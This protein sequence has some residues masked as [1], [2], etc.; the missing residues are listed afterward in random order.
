MLVSE[1]V[2]GMGDGG[3]AFLILEF[4][5]QYHHLHICIR[6]WQTVDNV[7]TIFS[8]IAFSLIF[9]IKIVITTNSTEDQYIYNF[10]EI[11][12]TNRV[13]IIEASWSPLLSRV[14]NFIS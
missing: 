1:D 11:P 8:Q 3:K 4:S 10:H 6:S 9:I 2:S 12:S 14:N 5:I 7:N 13:N